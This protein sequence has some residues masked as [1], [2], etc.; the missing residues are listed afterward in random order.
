MLL[1]IRE[2]SLM[3]RSPAETAAS[4]GLTVEVI[5]AWQGVRQQK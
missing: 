1:P 4:V 3:Q 5:Y 2:L